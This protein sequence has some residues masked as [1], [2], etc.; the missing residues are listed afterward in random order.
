MVSASPGLF[1]VTRPGNA[2]DISALIK[3]HGIR[4]VDLRFTDLPGLWQHF[5]IALPEVGPGLFSDGIGFDGSS[6]RGFQE[7]HE[8]DMLLKP[9]PTTAFVDPMCEVATLAIVCDVFDPLLRQP[10]SRDPRHIA[11]KAEAYLRGGGVAETC[12]FGPELEF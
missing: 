10:Y 4:I 9:D 7:I 11:K 1:Q 8:S 6:I 5:S 12:Y 3:Q 2:D